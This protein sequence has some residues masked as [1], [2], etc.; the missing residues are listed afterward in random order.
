MQECGLPAANHLLV[1]SYEDGTDNTGYHF[2]KPAVIDEQSLITVLNIGSEGRPFAVREGAPAGA[3][4]AERE[5]MPLLWACLVPP[6]AALVMTLKAN[7]KTERA[8]PALEKTSVE[9]TGSIVLRT[10]TSTWTT[11]Q[12]VRA[13]A[14]AAGVRS[15]RGAA[16]VAASIDLCAKKRRLA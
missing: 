8:V 6:G 2:D 14:R 15:K 1:T 7:L 11:E 4:A 12:M 13:T 9:R 10:I 5:K 3:T 16:Q